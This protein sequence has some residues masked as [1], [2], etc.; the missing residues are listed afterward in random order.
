MPASRKRS[1]A[2][3]TL[4]AVTLLGATIQLE[5]KSHKMTA[6]DLADRLGVDRSTL[7]RLEQGDPK[8]ELGIAFEACAILNIPLFEEDAPG[9]THRL[10]EAVKRLA[11]LPRRIRPASVDLRDDF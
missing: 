1:Y 6:Q 8:V 2:R 4:A 10:D 9:L 7:Q 11:L 3:Y 5:R